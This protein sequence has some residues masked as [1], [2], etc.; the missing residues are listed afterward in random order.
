MDSKSKRHHLVPRTY[1]SSWEHGQGTLYI[2][3]KDGTFMERNKNKIAY[4]TD[5]H[6]I[7]VDMP[8]CTKEDTDIIFECLTD[9][10]VEYHGE[11]IIDT[12][13]LN[14][15]YYDF[16][17]WNV[18]RKNGTPVSKKKLKNDIESVKIRDIEALWGTKY[19]NGWNELKE[20]IE[21]EVLSA[22]TDIITAFD[23]ESLMKFYTAMDW[24]GFKNNAQL[25]DVFNLI[26][27][28]V[29][30]FNEIKIP[31]HERNLSTIENVSDDL[32]H[33]YLLKQYREFFD[34]KG[35]IYQNVMANM[36]H[37]SFHFLVTDGADTFITSDNPAFVF[38]NSEG[39]LQGIMPITPRILLI[40]GKD[41]DKDDTYCIT[42]VSGDMVKFYN[43]I[44]WNNSVEFVILDK[45]IED[46]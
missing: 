6:S 2:K 39:K 36:K 40:Q 1:L 38:E 15:I 32:K 18:T 44:I 12:L 27:N 37:T 17:N 46:F 4:I 42:H 19:E 25:N 9:Y 29:L 20:K 8:I 33:N 31:E 13:E 14:K 23:K 16:E 3:Y 5:F 11:R 43:D 24:R 7:T 30:K 10:I 22:H 34:D 26:C 41:T 28:N 45:P 35:V 21:K